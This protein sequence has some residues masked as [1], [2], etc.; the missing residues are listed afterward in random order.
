VRER[1]LARILCWLS[2]ASKQA[3][4]F[5]WTKFLFPQKN[6]SLL[7]NNN[8]GV[9]KEFREQDFLFL[10]SFR[11]LSSCKDWMQ[12]E[13]LGFRSW[14]NVRSPGFWGRIGLKGRFNPIAQGKWGRI[15]RR[16]ARLGFFFL[17]SVRI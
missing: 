13:G 10:V 6:H 12:E 3:T 11:T 16:K 8:S 9:R 15:L 17:R 7:R 4:V 1:R 14:T 2:R 5:R